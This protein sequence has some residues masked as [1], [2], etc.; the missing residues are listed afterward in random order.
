MLL[1][2]RLL[3]L[4]ASYIPLTTSSFLYTVST[5]TSLVH[6]CPHGCSLRIGDTFEFILVWSQRALY[7]LPKWFS[8][9]DHNASS[10]GFTYI[11]TCIYL[12]KKTTSHASDGET[13]L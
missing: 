11:Q 2:G 8:R 7:G 10:V 3:G 4:F 12:E 5:T 1:Y 9:L 13:H 6:F